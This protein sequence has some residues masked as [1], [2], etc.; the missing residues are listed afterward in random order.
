MV[1]TMPPAPIGID[2]CFRRFIPFVR[3]IIGIRFV[4]SY[5]YFTSKIRV[6]SLRASQLL[7]VGIG[8]FVDLFWI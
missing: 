8:L 2:M 3:V 6:F 7:F 4:V 1:E 5:I